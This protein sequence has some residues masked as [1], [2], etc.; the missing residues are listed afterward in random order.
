MMRTLLAVLLLAASAA[1]QSFIMPTASALVLPA[2]DQFISY[3]FPFTPGQD[4]FWLP[5]K[6]NQAPPPCLLGLCPEGFSDYVVVKTAAKKYG[7]KS[8]VW[9]SDSHDIC[10]T[11]P[12]GYCTFAG[13]LSGH[14]TAVP[15]P[16]PDGSA[17]YSVTD[18]AIGQFID[19]TGA[20]HYNLTAIFNFITYATPN[21][22]GY[23]IPASGSLIV[24]ISPL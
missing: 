20:A 3:A 22:Y 19:A 5:Y 16:L 7:G 6:E 11:S 4:E 13:T 14:P 1:A 8:Y 2:H 10:G 17:A 21:K 18:L 12:L 24:E 9:L 23:G 15:I